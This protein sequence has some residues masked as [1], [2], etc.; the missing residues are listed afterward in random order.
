[1]S[2]KIKTLARG[3]AALEKLCLTRGMTQSELSRYLGVDRSTA[4][5]F[6]QTFEEEGYVFRDIQGR[7][8][9][10]LK[11]AEVARN[12]VDGI[13]VR[14]LASSH[15]QELAALTGFSTHLAVI[16][17]YRVVYVDG[18]EGSGMV[19]VNAEIGMNA[20]IHC[21]ATG[22]AM[23]AFQNQKEREEMIKQQEIN[24]GGLHA[25][26]EKTITSRDKLGEHL[27]IVTGKGYAVDDEEFEPGIRCLAAPVFDAENRAVAVIGISGT[28]SRLLSE[29]LAEQAA[30]VCK[31]ALEISRMMRLKNYE[32]L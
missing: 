19:K 7:Y 31:T 1:M 9:P 24:E 16:S 14:K 18:E 12:V 21:T 32:A 20:P 15:L 3:L 29:D 8:F 27:E 6:L 23:A 28:A 10:T 30:T 13:E 26:T 2:E 25:Y 22:K 17:D 11:I 4:L 5:R